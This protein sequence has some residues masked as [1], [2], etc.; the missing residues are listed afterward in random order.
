MGRNYFKNR[1]DNFKK[2]F[3]ERIN[4]AKIKYSWGDK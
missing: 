3:S 2:V 4:F 1:C